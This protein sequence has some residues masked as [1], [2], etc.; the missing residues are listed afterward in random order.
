MNT[1]SDFYA[2]IYAAIVVVIVAFML[3]GVSSALKPMQD[4]NIKLDKMKQILSSLHIKD[5]KDAKAEYEK[6]VKRDAVINAAGS[7]VKAEGGFDVPNDAITADNLP[8]YV[9][10]VNGEEK[11]VIPMTGQGLW[12][13]IWGY[14]AVNSDGNTI[15]GA[16]FSHASETPGLGAEI[17]SEKFTKLFDGK[18]LFSGNEVLKTVKGRLNNEAVEVNSISGATITCN[19]VNAMLDKCLNNYK[20]YLAGKQSNTNVESVKSVEE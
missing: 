4:E 11:Y 17:A 7:E 12:G 19:G 9:C 10:E 8:I 1:N 2:I 18:S 16:Y 3:A 15:Y 13:G 14:M 5:V 20:S 6:V